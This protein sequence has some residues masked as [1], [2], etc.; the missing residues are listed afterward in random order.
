MKFGVNYT[1]RV[2]WFHSWLDFDPARVDDDLAQIAE[3]GVDHVRIFPLWP[4]LQP[5]RTYIRP[6]AIDD[7]ATVV[8]LASKHR[9][10]AFVDVLNGHL[11]SFDYLP[12]WVLSWHG[13]NIF[14]DPEVVAA[15][16]ELVKTVAGAIKDIPGA[17]GVQLGNEIIQFAAGRHPSR[18]EITIP[19]AHQW[20]D[21]MLGAAREAWPE[22]MHSFNFDDD[23][24]FDATHP[25]D[26]AAAVTYGDLTTVHSWVFGQVGPRYGKDAPENLWFARYLCELAAGWSADPDR[27]IWLQEVGAPRNYVSDE[28]APDFVRE[29][30]GNL[31]NGHGSA[32]PKLEGITW[33]C[34]HD[35]NRELGDFPELEHTLGLID[36]NGNVKPEGEALR[37][38]AEL[39]GGGRVGTATAPLERPVMEISVSP[40]T[41]DATAP[42][43]EF[44]AT[45]VER[46]QAGEVPA[47][48]IATESLNSSHTVKEGSEN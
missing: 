44:F 47:I 2:G 19:Q 5:N 39:W 48:R 8:E 27:A 42:R 9:L 34:S 28:K 15:E 1:P 29:T 37:E 7:V 25:F 13:R 24:W 43:S 10:H 31:I 11:S 3:L 30:I 46:A 36:S 16:A 45:W 23:L 14:A 4:I 17:R 38:C 12:S 22:G 41:R 21:Q 6:K 35:V 18:H 40:E 33:W 26:P 32:A 20:L